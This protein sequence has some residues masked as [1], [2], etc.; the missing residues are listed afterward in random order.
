[1]G[2]EEATSLRNANCDFNVAPIVLSG[3]G[4]KCFNGRAVAARFYIGLC[5]TPRRIVSDEQ[6]LSLSPVGIPVKV[7]GRFSRV[8]Y[9]IFVRLSRRYYLISAN[10]ALSASCLP[11]TLARL[12]IVYLNFLPDRER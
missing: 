9:W 2:D 6:R 4:L 11:H 3:D 7:L 10:F 1:M 8:I 12:V 5:I